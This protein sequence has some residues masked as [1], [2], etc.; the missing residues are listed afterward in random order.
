MAY[1][2][3]LLPALLE[4]SGFFAAGYATAGHPEWFLYSLFAI[5]TALAVAFLQVTRERS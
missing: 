1:A 4:A 5:S 2:L 3:I